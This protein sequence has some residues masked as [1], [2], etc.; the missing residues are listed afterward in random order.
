MFHCTN[1]GVSQ[2]GI[3]A[4]SHGAMHATV[5]AVGSLWALSLEE[6]VRGRP[7]LWDPMGLKGTSPRSVLFLVHSYI[8]LLGESGGSDFVTHVVVFFLVGPASAA[9]L[10]SKIWFRALVH[11]CI[12]HCRN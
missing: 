10:G 9:Y 1:Q 6:G 3:F 12:E 5:L 7:L 11:G 8:P 2:G 4:A